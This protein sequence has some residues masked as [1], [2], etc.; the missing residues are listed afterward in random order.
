MI[1]FVLV[2][3][4]L[5]GAGFDVLLQPLEAGNDFLLIGKSRKGRDA[6]ANSGIQVKFRTM[7]AN[8][9]KMILQIRLNKIGHAVDIFKPQRF[10]WRLAPDLFR[11]LPGWNF[12]W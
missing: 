9:K 7:F 4:F 2:D 10:A 5:D 12:P 8:V 1:I 3:D 6:F 11:G